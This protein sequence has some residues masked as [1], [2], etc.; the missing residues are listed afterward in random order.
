ME[1]AQLTVQSSKGSERRLQLDLTGRRIT[2]ALSPNDALL[3]HVPKAVRADLS[4]RGFEVYA[5]EVE[6]VAESWVRINL[7][8]GRWQGAW[9]DG[10]TLHFL[11]PAPAVKGLGALP[12]GAGYV[13]YRL[14][15]LQIEGF[16]HD[17][18][19][20]PSTYRQWIDTLRPSLPA[21]KAGLRELLLTVVTD[22]EFSTRHGSNRDSVVMGRLN[23]VDGIYRNQLQVR[24]TLNHLR[25]L[26]DNGTL[27]MTG[28]SELLGAFRSFMNSAAA[29]S[30]PKGGLTHLFSGKDF[31]G[32]TAGV[33]YLGVLCNASYGYGIN[34]VRSETASTAVIIAHEMGHNFAASHDGGDSGCASGTWIMSPSVSGALD[35]FSQCSLDKIL[36]AMASASCLRAVNTTSGFYG[37][38]FEG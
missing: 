26:S 30:I 9:F 33:A 1:A 12:R 32:S 38:G 23:V 17:E 8:R 16:E 10:E 18:A 20:A 15:D 19:H 28:G 14:D 27:T 31:D 37:D 25:H 5:G 35:S 11:D 36:P 34:Q 3:R 22:S 24:V 7:D 6:G 29:S 13:V 4:A 21:S 2:L